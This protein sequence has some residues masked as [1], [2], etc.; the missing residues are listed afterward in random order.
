MNVTMKISTNKDPAQ[1]EVN[2]SMTFGTVAGL[3]KYI[4]TVR[5]ARNWLA[6]QKGSPKPGGTPTT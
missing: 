2:G 1:V 3:D 6:A 4:K 5:T